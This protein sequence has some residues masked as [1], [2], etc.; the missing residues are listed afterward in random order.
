LLSATP[1]KFPEAH[2]LCGI[3][4]SQP[5]NWGALSFRID[6]FSRALP[7]LVISFEPQLSLGRRL[8]RAFD[9]TALYMWRSN[10]LRLRKC[11]SAR[12]GRN[13]VNPRWHS[14]A[15][16]L[17]ISEEEFAGVLDGFLPEILAGEG[18]P[19]GMLYSARH[20]NMTDCSMQVSQSA[21]ESTLWRWLLSMR[22]LRGPDLF[23]RQPTVSLWTTKRVKRAQKK[24]SG[25]QTNC[26]RS[27]S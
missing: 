25:L 27:V 10:V 7:V 13:G 2:G 15:K 9:A 3:S 20:Q 1:E 22:E 23:C 17:P 14:S 21:A 11:S 16:G 18:R 4:K 6:Q 12:I 5:R 26:T 24:P 8:A 19:L